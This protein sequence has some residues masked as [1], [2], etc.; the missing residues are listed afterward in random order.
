MAREA[1][2]TEAV[3]EAAE[4]VEPAEGEGGATGAGLGASW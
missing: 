1:L 2:L 4:A 3:A